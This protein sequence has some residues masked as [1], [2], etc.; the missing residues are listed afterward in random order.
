MH[1]KFINRAFN[2]F[3]FFFNLI[4]TS[5]TCIH[6][7]VVYISPWLDMYACNNAQAASTCRYNSSNIITFMIRTDEMLGIF[8]I[9]RILS[10]Y[11]YSDQCLCLHH[12]LNS[13]QYTRNNY[14][15]WSIFNFS[16]YVGFVFK[17]LYIVYVRLETS[18]LPMKGGKI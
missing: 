17:Q 3:S 10:I 15:T 12:W 16:M 8:R 11:K 13:A 5:G 18:P 14:N 6:V 9:F 1:A 7:L 2:W 4:F